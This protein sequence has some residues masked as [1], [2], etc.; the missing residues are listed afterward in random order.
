[1]RN[2]ILITSIAVSICIIGCSRESPSVNARKC[3]GFLI[4]YKYAE[5]PEDLKS[6]HWTVFD[7]LALVAEKESPDSAMAIF[8]EFYRNKSEVSNIK[9]DLGQDQLLAINR[10][11]L[12]SCDSGAIYIPHGDN[13]FYPALFLQKVC[14]IRP[15]I[16][17]FHNSLGTQKKFREF[18]AGD[19]RIERLFSREEWLAGPPDSLDPIRWVAL[20]AIEKGQDSPPVHFATMCRPGLSQESF[21]QQGITFKVGTPPDSLEW[22]R[23]NSRLLKEKFPA[24]PFENG[25][26]RRILELGWCLMP[27]S[28][29]AHCVSSF[30]KIGQKKEAGALYK[31]LSPAFAG[32][33][34]WWL[35]GFYNAE[36]IAVE[37]EFVIDGIKK[38]LNSVEPDTT[39]F[40]KALIKILEDHER[41]KS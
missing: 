25:W 37:K 1:M 40:D 29:G 24:K 11:A 22:T 5:M 34:R 13:D 10:F 35:Y 41:E 39:T 27:F 7:S 23:L 31:D 30:E 14:G 18:L 9:T 26:D 15:D 3:M 21:Y 2:S 28:L 12:E 4:K 16:L 17:I 6:L 19:P 36:D 32:M 8:R 33:Q 38:Y 20:R